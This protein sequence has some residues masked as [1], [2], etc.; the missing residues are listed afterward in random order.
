MRRGFTL[1]ELLV[2]IAIIGV[3]VAL[4][5]PAV[6]SARESARVT[7]CRNNVRQQ[8]LALHMYHD[9]HNLFP[10]ATT[11]SPASAYGFSWMVMILPFS[12]NGNLYSQLDL[13]GANH[14]STGLIY[15]PNSAYPSGANMFNGNLVKG[16]FIPIYFCPSSPLSKWRMQTLTPPGP[17][18]VLGPTYTAICGAVDH[19]STLNRDGETNQHNGVGKLSYGGAMSLHKGWRIGDVLD[20]TSQTAIVGEQS[21][22]CLTNTRQKVDCRSDYGHGWTMGSHKSE[23]RTFNATSVRYPINS[24]N[25]N[26]TGVG[27]PYYALNRPIQAV[28]AGGAMVL[29]AD[30]SVQLLRQQLALQTWFDLC[31]RDDGHS[32]PSL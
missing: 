11:H 19:S 23:F 4:L 17:Q 16:M 31:N 7:Q 32:I 26:L 27:E 6:Q 18:G 24:K 9:A 21:D 2:V 29:F 3:L 5:L 15:G 25:W 1:V 8:G 10:A 14:A 28:H 20:G 22:F 30:G 13:T 12:E